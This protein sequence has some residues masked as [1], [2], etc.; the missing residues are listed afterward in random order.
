VRSV[1]GSITRPACPAGQ[2]VYFQTSSTVVSTRFGEESMPL[3]PQLAQVL[4]F[5]DTL[6]GPS[7]SELAPAAAR[8]SFARF[9]VGYRT[10]ESLEP[11]ASVRDSAIDGSGG[12]LPVRIYRPLADEQPLPTVVFFHG[13]G[14]VLGNIETHED[15]ARHICRRAGAVV[16]SV[17]YRLAPE[18]PFPAAV[19]DA[20]AATEWAVGNAAEL[21]GDPARVAVAGDSAGANLAAVTA[22]EL[23][24]SLAAQLLI[25]PVVDYDPAAN[26]PSRERNSEGYFLTAADMHYFNVQYVP[27]GADRD[28]PRLSPLRGKLEGLPPAVVLTAEYDPLRDEGLAYADALRAAGVQVQAHDFPGLVHGFFG[29]SSVSAAAADAV[30]TGCTAF[31]DLL[32]A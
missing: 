2:A 4:A 26:Y 1:T 24:E 31:G 5:L 27:E 10:A 6:G 17:D 18:N 3:D 11:V 16:V 25:Y 32:R 21:G 30:A 28:D 22:Q 9:T 29:M 23:R 19:R 8:E 13:G 12:R 15:Q 14:F 7:V 20:V